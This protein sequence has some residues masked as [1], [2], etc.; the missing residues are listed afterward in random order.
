MGYPWK[1]WWSIRVRFYWIPYVIM[2]HH[3]L[4]FIL[5][6]LKLKRTTVHTLWS[7]SYVIILESVT[8]HIV[9]MMSWI[10]VAD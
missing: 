7:T 6:A 9:A 3:L 4:I 8:C 2:L 10:F 5:C 1:R